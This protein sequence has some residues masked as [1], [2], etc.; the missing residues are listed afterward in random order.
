MQL[1]MT[2]EQARV[3]WAALM[4]RAARE[5]EY[6]ALLELRKLPYDKHH[7]QSLVSEALAN[8]IARQCPSVA[9]PLEDQCDS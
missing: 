5:L 7:R 1:Q 2:E 9:K 3:A 6:C 8:E 4:L